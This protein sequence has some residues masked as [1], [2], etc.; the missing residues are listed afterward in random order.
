[1]RYHYFVSHLFYFL[2]H[3]LSY[4]LFSSCLIS[5]GICLIVPCLIFSLILSISVFELHDV[6]TDI[7]KHIWVEIKAYLIPTKS[8]HIWNFWSV[9]FYC[10]FS[11][12]VK[13]LSWHVYTL[14]DSISFSFFLLIDLASPMLDLIRLLIFGGKGCSSGRFFDRRLVPLRGTRT[15]FTWVTTTSVWVFVWKHWDCNLCVLF[16]TLTGY[17]CSRYQHITGTT[18]DKN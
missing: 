7:G 10:G 12:A 18:V 16:L 11:S 13:N 4:Y 1:M 9:T 2:S 15:L 8:L 6:L 17:F 14:H 3:H 5:F